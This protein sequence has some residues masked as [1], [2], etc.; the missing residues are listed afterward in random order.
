MAWASCTKALRNSVWEIGTRRV[1]S[2]MAASSRSVGTP[3]P[4]SEETVTI[5]APFFVSPSI[6]YMTLGKFSSV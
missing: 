4:S 6:R 2:S 5:S 3:M 1:R